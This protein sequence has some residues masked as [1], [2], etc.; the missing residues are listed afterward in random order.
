LLEDNDEK[1][2]ERLAEIY[3]RLDEIEAHLAEHKASSILHGLGFDDEM[4]QRATRDFS[5]GWRMRISL[6]RA[7]FRQPR[8]LLLDEPTNHLDLNAVIWLENYLLKW[9]NTLF[10]VSHDQDFLNSV[11]TDIYHLHQQNLAHYKGNYDKF[12]HEFVQMVD[13]E[14]K[15]YDKQQ[16]MIKSQNQQKRKTKSGQEKAKEAAKFAARDSKKKNDKKSDQK[17]KPA[18][19]ARPPKDYTVN[20]EFPDSPR[21]DGIFLQIKEVSFGY[22]N[23]PLLFKNVT[24]G[25]DEQSK[26]ALVGNNGTGKSTLLKLIIGKIDPISGEVT[27]NRKLVIGRF[28]QH[29]VDQLTMDKNPVEYLTSLFPTKNPQEIRSMLG[30][31]G[32]PGANHLQPITSLSGGQ[33]SRVVFAEICGRSPQLLLLDEPTNHLDLES[34]E[35]LAEG[36]NNFEGAVLMVS[37]DSRLITE[38][39]SDLWICKNQGVT[40]YDGDFQ[41]YREMLLEEFRKREEE[42][43]KKREEREEQRRVQREARVASLVSKQRQK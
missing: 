23:K 14:R 39:C 26:I 25:I 32:L 27:R 40:P 34:I 29:F 2:G 30:R 12:K 22:P 20:F 7:L 15:A 4:K 43:L 33:K 5:G 16:K 35:A 38:V 31:V 17:E 3:T 21:L 11:C 8:L 19:L 1:N 42:E 36:L 28:S 37:H 9:K 41:D 10:V 24:I 13:G 6:A 18:L